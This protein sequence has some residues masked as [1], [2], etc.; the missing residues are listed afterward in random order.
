LLLRNN[1]DQNIIKRASL[2]RTDSVHGKFPGTVVADLENKALIIN[3]QS[4]KLIKVSN[5]NEVDYTPYGID[6][7]L[8]IDNT[9]AYRDKEALGSICSQKVFLKFY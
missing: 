2:L 5:P 6:N 9:G 4:V 1:D 3:G 8:L 7:A